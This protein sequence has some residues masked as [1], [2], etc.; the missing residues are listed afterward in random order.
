MYIQSVRI[1]AA[2]AAIVAFLPSAGTLA[3]DP[4]FAFGKKD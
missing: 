3:D 2:S 4:K 1:L